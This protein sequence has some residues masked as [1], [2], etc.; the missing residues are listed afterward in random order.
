M[1]RSLQK[2]ILITCKNSI[3]DVEQKHLCK[4]SHR[5]SPYSLLEVNR[6]DATIENH[7]L[8]AK[9]ENRADKETN[10]KFSCPQEKTISFRI[11]CDKLRLGWLTRKEHKTSLRGV[12]V[13]KPANNLVIFIIFVIF[14]FFSEEFIILPFFI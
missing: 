3:E 4:W 1:L 11:A 12:R 2:E 13:T 6:R 9:I 14:V 5:L 8:E 10:S 7:Q